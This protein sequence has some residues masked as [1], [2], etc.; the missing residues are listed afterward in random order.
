MHVFVY[1]H[2]THSCLLI[3]ALQ[4]QI[5][6]CVWSLVLSCSI[7]HSILILK[8]ILTRYHTSEHIQHMVKYHW[9]SVILLLRCWWSWSPSDHYYTKALL[10]N[11]RIS[12][13][14]TNFNFKSQ[15]SVEWEFSL[16]YVLFRTTFA[17]RLQTYLQIVKNPNIKFIFLTD[18][19][20]VC[21]SPFPKLKNESSK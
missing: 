21:F 12:N 15:I 19:Q 14:L 7:F 4:L 11:L 9:N 3:L 13:H 17:T 20:V 1:L 2:Y 18:V 5:Q 6:V 16:Y 8:F 10:W